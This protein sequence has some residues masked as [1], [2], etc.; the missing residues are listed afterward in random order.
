MYLD[1]S[2]YI[3][4]FLL[5][6]ESGSQQLIATFSKEVVEKLFYCYSLEN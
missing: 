6:E 1:N 5:G 2:K 3:L 4:L